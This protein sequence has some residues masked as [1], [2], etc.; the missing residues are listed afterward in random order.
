MFDSDLTLEQAQRYGRSLVPWVIDERDLVV[1]NR[2]RREAV[3]Q[4]GSCLKMSDG[5]SYQ[6]QESPRHRP[7]PKKEVMV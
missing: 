3:K 1:I 5:H 2:T 4:T 7:Y 6:V